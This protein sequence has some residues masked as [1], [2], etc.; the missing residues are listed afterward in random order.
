MWLLAVTSQLQT[1]SSNKE[2]EGE[3]K[4]KEDEEEDK[5]ENEQSTEGKHPAALVLRVECTAIVL[6]RL[7]VVIAFTTTSRRA[8]CANRWKREKRYSIPPE[9][10]DGGGFFALLFLCVR[11]CVLFL[12]VPERICS[13]RVLLKLKERESEIHL[14]NLRLLQGTTSA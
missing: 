9:E 3:E 2:E 1:A 14:Q 4:K 8:P 11:A 6:D 7:T 5:R 13:W 10:D 12:G